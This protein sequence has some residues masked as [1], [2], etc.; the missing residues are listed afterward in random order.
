M[1]EGMRSTLRVS[2]CELVR[3]VHAAAAE[4]P[5]RVLDQYVNRLQQGIRGV[6]V[7]EA[8][9]ACCWFHKDMCARRCVLRVRMTGHLRVLLRS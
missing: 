8:T 6:L 2:M 5:A 1:L 3:W 7:E 4:A 9:H